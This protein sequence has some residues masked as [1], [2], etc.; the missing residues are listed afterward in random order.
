MTKKQAFFVLIFLLFVSLFFHQ[1]AWDF[2]L[3]LQEIKFVY[4]VY[5]I[6]IGYRHYS[7]L[8]DV[9]TNKGYL[10]AISRHG[11]NR[12]TCGCD[13]CFVFVCVFACLYVNVCVCGW[14]YIS[15]GSTHEEGRDSQGMPSPFLEYP[16]LIEAWGGG[17][18]Q[19]MLLKEYHLICPHST[20]PRL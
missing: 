7:V 10:M 1:W 4:D 19:P 12:Q 8:C 11:I 15:S 2:P 3:S 17:N 20:C 18:H 13:A 16:Q 9:M 5:G 14:V 6:N